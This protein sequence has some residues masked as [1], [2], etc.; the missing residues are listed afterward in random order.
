MVNP[1]LAWLVAR[2]SG[3]V[4]W[5]LLTVAVVWGLALRTRVLGSRPTP[6]WLL[7]LHRGLGGLGTVFTGVHVAA[8]VLDDYIEFGPVEVLVPLTSEW[9]PGAVALGVVALYLLVAVEVTSLLQRRLPA[10][11]WR[12]VHLASL[13][14]WVVATAHLLTAGTDARS[15]AVVWSLL[16][17]VALM[18]FL[19]LFRALAPRRKRRSERRSERGSGPRGRGLGSPTDRAAAYD[20]P[21]SSAAIERS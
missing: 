1:Q 9:R 21:P 19:A 15:P 10:R 5:A 18:V 2:S 11:W 7:D 4:A 6:R 20:G 16:A 8:L 13:P 14:L 17:S 3:L 12:R